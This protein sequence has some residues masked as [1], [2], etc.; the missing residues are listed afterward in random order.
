MCDMCSCGTHFIRRSHSLGEM[1]QS[2]WSSCI[3]G[4]YFV[5]MIWPVFSHTHCSILATKV[6]LGITL[7]GKSCQ[8]QTLTPSTSSNDLIGSSSSHMTVPSRQS[9]ISELGPGSQK[10]NMKGCNKCR[11]KPLA[12]VER[13]TLCSNRII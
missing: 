8:Y 2:Y 13:F 4:E 12:E 3:Y 5:F 1:E 10:S 9:S 6:L 7:F 11:S